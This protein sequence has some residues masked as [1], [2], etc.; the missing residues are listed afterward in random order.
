LALLEV[1]FHLMANKT[2]P[3]TEELFGYVL[4]NWVHEPVILKRLREETAT[5]P[6]AGMQISPDQGQLMAVITKL[7]NVK[8]YLEVGV[9]TGYSSL[10]VALALPSDGHV[11][12]C[13]VSEEFTSMARRYWTEAGVAG[14]ID[15]RIAPAIQTL[16]NLIREGR[17][18]DMAFIDADKPGYSG[19]YEQCLQLVKPGGLILVDN[20]LWSGRVADPEQRDEST[21]LI[22]EFNRKL[23]EDDRIDLALIPIADGLTVARVR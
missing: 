2:I 19:Y 13:D 10:S 14:K 11:V 7:L 21:I 23:H 6:N 9:F 16:G 22:R 15:L 20:V 5:M 17:G 8:S 18:F 12:A 1:G 4:N 3:M